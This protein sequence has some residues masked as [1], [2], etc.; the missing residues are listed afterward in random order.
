MAASTLFAGDVAV[1]QE[2][3]PDFK[4]HPFLEFDIEENRSA[5]VALADMDSD[6]DL[7]VIVA[8]GRHWAQQDF[9]FFNIGNGK[10]LEALPLG[11][12]K[13]AS[14]TVQAGDLDGDGDIDA[15]VV[16]D[17]L[18][19]L[20]FSN[21][22]RGILTLVGK[23]PDSDGQAR[24]AILFHADGNGSL[25]LAVVT[26]R[27]SDRLYLGNGHGGFYTGVD[28]PDDG[29]GST[30]VASGDLDADGDI[31]L[32]IARRDGAAS[33]VMRNDGGNNFYPL[34]LAGS[35]G[36]HRKTAIADLNGDG[37]LD[38][39]LVST[40]GL[41]LLYLQDNQGDYSSFVSFGDKNDTVQA[42]A[43]GDLDRDG[44]TDLV[45]GADGANIVYNNDGTGVFV[46]QTIPSDA[47]TYGVAVGD[48]DGDG[49]LDIVFANSG[50][51]NEVVLST[52]TNVNG[53]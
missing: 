12:S 2:A 47:D 19:A 33:V 28:L 37:K 23:I 26:R 44:D 5:D 40:D 20:S 17:T 25:D 49:F 38:I 1:A 29:F 31:D 11:L 51:A 35:E 48:M 15:V 32:V 36:D 53:E 34:K 6:G 42:L 18:P 10:L 39:V 21:D 22:G 46:R 30:G 45:A 8:N 3:S 52:R 27:G 7:D 50:S 4:Q 43:V 14:Y 13:S 41:H 9:I 16:R 24:S